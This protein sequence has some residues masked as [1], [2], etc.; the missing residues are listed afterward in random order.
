GIPIAGLSMQ[1][2]ERRS[3]ALTV[4]LLA[5][6]L[7]AYFVLFVPPSLAD[8]GRLSLSTNYDFQSYFLPRF[9]YGSEELAHF[10]FPLWNPYEYGGVPFFATA[11]PEVLYP[12]KALLFA[13]FRPDRAYWLFMVLHFIGLVVGFV[14]FAREQG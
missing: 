9:V 13:L 12:P 11:Q 3:L 1:P 5:V 8:L 4:A 10:R 2:A 6:C 14:L 7:L